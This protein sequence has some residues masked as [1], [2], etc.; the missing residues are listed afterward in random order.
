MSAKFGVRPGPRPNLPRTGGPRLTPI[1]GSAAVAQQQQQQP[2]PPPAPEPAP[3]VAP[4]PAPPL[5][6]RHAT[7]RPTW[8][9]IAVAPTVSAGVRR[10]ELRRWHVRAAI[11]SFVALAVGAFG[12]G[13]ALGERGDEEQLDSAYGML[14]EADVTMSALADT[15]RALRIAATLPTLAAAT[16]ATGAAAADGAKRAA[17]PFSRFSL[18]VAGR[19]SSGFARARRH[20][21]L[22]IWR[23]HDGMDISAPRGTPIHTPASGRVMRVERQLGYGL[24]VEVNHGGGVHTWYAHLNAARVTVGQRVAAGTTIGT[25]GSSGLATGPHLHYEVRV[26]GRRVNPARYA[27]AEP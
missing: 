23:S 22:G 10:F 4:A 18:P 21:I 20:P 16:P 11:I 15:L 24:V 8:T 17:R 2:L 1:H 5:V 26:K 19:V 3:T 27:F 6:R 14:T 7:R 9:L 13:L 12:A 25:V